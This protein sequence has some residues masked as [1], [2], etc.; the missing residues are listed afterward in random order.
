MEPKT[1]KETKTC[2]SRIDC[3]LPFGVDVIPALLKR[4]EINDIAVASRYHG[5]QSNRAPFVRKVCSRL[6]YFLCKLLFNIPVA[7]IG[8][9]S[10][11]MRSR[12]PDGIDLKADGFDIHA[13]FYL[14][15][16]KKG[17]RIEEMPVKFNMPKQGSFHVWAHGPD[18]L[19]KTFKLYFESLEGA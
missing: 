8:S 16:F 5:G 4:L 12:V 15:V 2:G 1:N 14:K 3:D 18:A 11:A 9:G 10:V 13:E 19:V 6:Y 7:D 17:F